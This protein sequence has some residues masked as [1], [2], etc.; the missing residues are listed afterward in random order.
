MRVANLYA[1]FFLFLHR[2]C[3]LVGVQLYI[4]SK[5]GVKVLNRKADSIMPA[6]EDIRQIDPSKVVFFAD[7]LVDSFSLSGSIII[8]SP[9]YNL[10]KGILENTPSSSQDYFDRENTGSLDGRFPLVVKK[11]TIKSHERCTDLN[12]QSMVAGVYKHPQVTYF[13]KNYYAI[14]GKHRLAMAA[15]LGKNVTC[16][17]V[18]LKDVLASQYIQKIYHKMS[19]YPKKYSKNLEL[20]SS[21]ITSNS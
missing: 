8:D 15:Y 5:C 6:I 9:H 19:K 14:D 18:S 7:G 4:Y 21:M 17:I 16:D 2:I 13:K 3:K 10:V 20:L 1:S 12:Y 11:E